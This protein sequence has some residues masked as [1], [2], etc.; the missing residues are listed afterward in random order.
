MT[1]ELTPDDA[2]V[3]VMTGATF[4]SGAAA[5]Q[6]IARRP[7]V[8][9][10][11]G[12]RGIGRTVPAGVETLPLD[13]ASLGGV[14]EFAAAVASRLGGT[15]IDALVLTAATLSRYA[16]GRTTDGFETAFG[17]NLLAHCLPARL[18]SRVS[19]TTHG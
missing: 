11:V 17:V 19:P 4:G 8:L 16:G 13:L 10:I 2:R 14:R 3:V 12:A 15:P 7:G 5:V 1:D 6:E 18:G 9:V